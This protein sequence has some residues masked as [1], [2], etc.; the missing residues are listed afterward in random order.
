MRVGVLARKLGM[1]QRFLDDGTRLPVTVLTLDGCQVVRTSAAV[2]DGVVSVQLGFG[3]VKTSRVSKPLRG[4]FAKQGVEPKRHLQEC[5][6]TAVNAPEQGAVLQADHFIPGQ[7]VDVAGIT[8]GRGFAGP[9]KRHNFGGLRASHG[10]SISHRSHGSTGGRQDPGK[11][12][13]NKKMAGHMGQVQVTTQNLKVVAVDVDRGLL[14]VKG[15]VPGGEN[16]IVYVKDA[17]KKRQPVK[18]PAPGSFRLTKSV[19]VDV[20]VADVVAG[21]NDAA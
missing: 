15:C 6:V 10:V 9:M 20:P 7:F 1:T 16:T 17:V 3:T 19:Q 18:L 8:I 5:L 4:Y 14:F 21:G 13:K 2:Q 12:F 11:T